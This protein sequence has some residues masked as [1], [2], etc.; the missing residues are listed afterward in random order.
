MYRIHPKQKSWSRPEEGWALKV[1]PPR[2]PQCQC[3]QGTRYCVGRRGMLSS[4]LL[5]PTPT[6][7]VR[8]SRSGC[9]DFSA[10]KSRYVFHESCTAVVGVVGSE[11]Q[12]L[13]ITATSRRRW[14]GADATRTVDKARPS[15][16]RDSPVLITLV[17]VIRLRAHCC[18]LVE[19]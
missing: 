5:S 15:P 18:S 6:L 7:L 1:N 2:A 17:I 3:S 11:R 10:R 19:C 13:L 16:F 4:Q 9:H 12:P 8:S 14:L